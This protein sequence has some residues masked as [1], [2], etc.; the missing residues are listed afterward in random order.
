M[1]GLISNPQKTIKKNF[2][3]AGYFLL[4]CVLINNYSILTFKKNSRMKKLFVIMAMAALASCGGSETAATT[5]S[6]TVA[7]DSTATVD[8]TVA[9]DTTA[10]ADTTAAA[11]TSAK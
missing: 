1:Q 6:T 7:V 5:D 10:V 8:S 2:F 11:D 4:L 9:V 3:N